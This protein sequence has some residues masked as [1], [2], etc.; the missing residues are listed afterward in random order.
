MRW[1]A[2]LIPGLCLVPGQSS[3]GAFNE[4]GGHGQVIVTRETSSASQY[5]QSNGTSRLPVDFAMRQRTVLI[6]Y[7]LTDRLMAI[8]KFSQVAASTAGAASYDGRG[9]TDVGLQVRLP[10][11]AGLTF[12]AQVMQHMPSALMRQGSWLYGQTRAES[13]LRLLAGKVTTMFGRRTFLDVQTGYR[14]RNDG[15]GR[16]WHFDV[17]HG[18]DVAPAT[19]LLVQ[20]FT[21]QASARPDNAYAL[22][23]QH[24]RQVSLV[25]NFGPFSLQIGAFRT[26]SGRRTYVERGSLVALWMSF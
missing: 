21:T 10:S 12:A 6:Q 8:L 20:T 25:R 5:V 2:P 16:E 15:L 22:F 1:L 19:T 4:P 26:L 11:M 14:L 13:E 3:A 24:K 23:E 9:P 18:I 17:T 7:G